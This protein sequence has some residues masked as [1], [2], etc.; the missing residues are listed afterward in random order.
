MQEKTRNVI[1]QSFFSGP[2][3]LK[4][5]IL[6]VASE[7]VDGIKLYILCNYRRNDIII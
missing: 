3:Q 2:E 4:I 1:I 6:S 5:I 7:L